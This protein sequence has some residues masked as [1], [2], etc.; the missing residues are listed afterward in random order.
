M[1]S[2]PVILII[3]VTCKLQKVAKKTQACNEC[4]TYLFGDLEPLW[5]Q[6][7]RDTYSYDKVDKVNPAGL[8][9]TKKF[10]LLQVQLTNDYFSLYSVIVDLPGKVS[11]EKNCFW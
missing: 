1:R 9:M 10:V 11:L 6:Y 2:G 3:T 4:K 7:Y 5:Q 8:V